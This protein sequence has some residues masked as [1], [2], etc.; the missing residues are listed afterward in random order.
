MQ[1]SPELPPDLQYVAL[2]LDQIEFFVPKD[3]ECLGPNVPER[4]QKQFFY[5]VRVNKFSF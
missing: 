3:A 2:K 4:I 1:F 5:F